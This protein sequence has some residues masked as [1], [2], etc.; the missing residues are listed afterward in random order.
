MQKIART[1]TKTRANGKKGIKVG[2]EEIS[3]TVNVTT[4]ESKVTVRR[5]AGRSTPTSTLQIRKAVRPFLYN[6][7]VS[8]VAYFDDID[9]N[10]DTND[11]A[12][13]K[14]FG[15][16]EE[17]KTDLDSFVNDDSSFIGVLEKGT[18]DKSSR[19]LNQKWRSK[20]RPHN[21]KK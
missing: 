6:L 18:S 21:L 13:D 16:N 17:D 3:S 14:I 19:R 7:L 1:K 15:N 2:T 8:N 10:L 20:R 11:G 4:V 9:T 5:I 12:T